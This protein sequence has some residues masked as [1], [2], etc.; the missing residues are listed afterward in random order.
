MGKQ[1]GISDI[2]SRIK[3]I[4]KKDTT[5]DS[6][7]L[8]KF[9]DV[10]N[11]PMIASGSYKFV[12]KKTKQESFVEISVFGG[13]VVGNFPIFDKEIISN[14]DNGATVSQKFTSPPFGKLISLSFTGKDKRPQV[15]RVQN[16]SNTMVSI[17]ILPTTLTE[18]I[19]I[20]DL[21]VMRL[22]EVPSAKTY[23]QM[24]GRGNR[25]C[26]GR[27]V[28]PKRDLEVMLYMLSAD[29]Y[30]EY[31]SDLLKRLRIELHNFK[32]KDSVEDNFHKIAVDYHLLYDLHVSVQTSGT[33]SFMK[34]IDKITGKKAN[35][36]F[37]SYYMGSEEVKLIYEWFRSFFKICK[38]QRDHARSTMCTDQ[39]SCE[40]SPLYCMKASDGKCD[41]RSHGSPCDYAIDEMVHFNEWVKNINPDLVINAFGIAALSEVSVMAMKEL[42]VVQRK[43]VPS[44]NAKRPS[45]GLLKK[46]DELLNLVKALN[47]SPGMSDNDVILL[48]VCLLAQHMMSTNKF[49]SAYE[50]L[51]IF[52]AQLSLKLY[53]LG[54]MRSDFSDDMLFKFNILNMLPF[55]SKEQFEKYDCNYYG[56]NSLVNFYNK[57]ISSGFVWATSP[58]HLMLPI[59]TLLLLTLR[60]SYENAKENPQ[61]GEDDDDEDDDDEDEDDDDDD[62]GDANEDVNLDD[63]D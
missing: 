12:F 2:A 62:E 34:H 31:E 28:S 47:V 10:V 4:T 1:E 54:T 15:V 32:G 5:E 8:S 33:S 19:S 3:S 42:V 44:L 7:A 52:T 46:C 61:D 39:G 50:W 36:Y 26:R 45:D 40:V 6:K 17:V 59:L 23:L 41:L 9:Y 11:T 58:Y 35:Q 51:P 30:K 38:K 24:I 43:D 56:N 21:D 14:I 20:F 29:V 49:C 60:T 13:N 18:G 55:I 25:F 57:Y 27:T 63:V 53:G 16:L 48:T 37:H 22:M